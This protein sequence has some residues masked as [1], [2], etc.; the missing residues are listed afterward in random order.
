M[1]ILNRF[2]IAFWP[3]AVT[4]TA[5]VILCKLG[6]W[7][8][9]RAEQKRNLLQEHRSQ[10]LLNFDQFA[11]IANDSPEV[12][13]GR[14]VQVRVL[15]TD[16]VMWLI[17][18]K[19]NQGKVGYSIVVPVQLVGTELRFLVDL[20]WWPAPE[21]RSELP[22]IQLPNNFDVIGKI[23]ADKFDSFQLGESEISD[24]WPQRI[25]S[26]KTAVYYD[27]S[28][29]ILPIV[30]FAQSNTILGH[31]QLYKPVVMPPEKHEA[32][33]LQWFLLAG[34]ALVVFLAASYRKEPK[35]VTPTKED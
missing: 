8:L 21:Q 11:S 34:F 14:E 5:F 12:L 3:L 30:V 6:M 22:K 1:I 4:L 24:S 28:S 13:H 10:T 33:A 17:D 31:P 7:Q 27:Y 16:D 29:P 23:K 19:V 2:S 26:L 25:Q 32:Y 15:R 35:P 18:N 20:G 9:D